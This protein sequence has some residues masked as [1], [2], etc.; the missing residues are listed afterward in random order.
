ALFPLNDAS[1]AP[2]AV[3][4]VITDI[5]DRVAAQRE[6]ERAQRRF[7]ALLESAPDATLITDGSGIV[8]MANAQVQ[9]VFGRLP[10]DLVGTRVA[11]L[12]PDGKRRRQGMLLDAYLR[13][14]DPQ[15]VVVDRDLYGT[16]GD[17]SPFPVEVSISSLQA[18]QE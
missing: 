17:G 8:V 5:T 4:G 3:C 13:R 6:V 9:R 1:G 12:A 2:Y 18:G 10:G 16:R 7:R 15:P 11:D 14:R